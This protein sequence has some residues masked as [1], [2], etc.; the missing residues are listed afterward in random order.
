VKAKSLPR[1]FLFTVTAI[2]LLT[3]AAKTVALLQDSPTVFEDWSPT[4]RSLP[5]PYLPR[6]TTGDMMWVGVGFEL[7]VLLALTRLRTDTSRLLLVAFVG[8]VFAAYHLGLG[9]IGYHHPCGCLGGPLDWLHLSRGA[10]DALTQAIIVY[11][12]AG[13]YGLL[14]WE[15]WPSLRPRPAHTRAELGPPTATP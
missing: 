15:A 13:S 10:Y 6:L 7:L 11:L 9:V 5:S 3:A 2:L 4:L 14:A 12:L 8:G 1:L